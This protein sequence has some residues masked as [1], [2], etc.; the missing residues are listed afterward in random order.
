MG[1]NKLS[2]EKRVQIINLLVEGMSI[3]AAQRITGASKVT[4]LKLLAD[5]GKVCQEFHDRTVVHV[6]AQRIQCDELWA[7]CYSKARN[8]PEE[9]RGLEGYG[10]VWTWTAIDA[11]SKLM[12]SYLVG[13][14]DMDYGRA[15]MRDL[16]DRLAG[17]VQITTDGYGAY[18]KAIN[19]TFGQGQVDFAQLIK[20]YGSE[21]NEYARYSAP[22]C[23][24][25]K[26]VAMRGAPDPAHISTSFVERS[27]LTLRMSQRRFTRL[28]NAFSKKLDNLK[29]A[30]ALHFVHYNFC[31]VHSSIKTT[32][33]VM[34]GLATKIWNIGDIVDLLGD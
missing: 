28:T 25:C 32:P 14:R 21:R 26:R 9:K 17:R 20:V 5:I 3:R 2:K 33:A 24:G 27:N 10:D 6:E 34:S 7:F 19:A 13:T 8:I 31:R 18:Q 1:M 30:V 22:E 23:I 29:H 12:V 11:D 16:A 4:I 15:F